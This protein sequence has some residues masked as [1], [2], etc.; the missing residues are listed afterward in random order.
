MGMNMG[1]DIHIDIKHA[2]QHRMLFVIKTHLDKN[3]RD[4]RQWKLQYLEVL[5]RNTDITGVVNDIH[6]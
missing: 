1:V 5:R 2:W 4:L 6:K 3:R